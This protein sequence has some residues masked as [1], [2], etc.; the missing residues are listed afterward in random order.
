M[1]NSFLRKLGSRKWNFYSCSFWTFFFTL[2]LRPFFHKMNYAILIF[3]LALYKVSL[4]SLAQYWYPVNS[5]YHYCNVTIK[6]KTCFHVQGKKWSL[7]HSKQYIHGY[8][9]PVLILSQMPTLQEIS[10]FSNT[11]TTIFPGYSSLALVFSITKFVCLTCFPYF[12][13][14]FL[15]EFNE[16]YRKFISWAMNKKKHWITLIQSKDPWKYKAYIW[17]HNHN[18]H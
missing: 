4:C 7:S 5:N 17:N 13:L 18:A 1:S 9:W 12:S 16:R 11:K 15:M 2:I 3:V 8:V 6:K 10:W 14:Y